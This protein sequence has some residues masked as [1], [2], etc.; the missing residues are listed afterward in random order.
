M[1]LSSTSTADPDLHA[2]LWALQQLAFLRTPGLLICNQPATIQCTPL[3]NP[4]LHC[5]DISV[6]AT[7]QLAK[8]SELDDVRITSGDNFL[9]PS[10]QTIEI[11]HTRTPP[12]PPSETAQTKPPASTEKPADKEVQTRPPA[13][14]NKATV[15]P[16]T[17]AP[18][19]MAT[20]HALEL[21]AQLGLPVPPEAKQL[22]GQ[23]LGLFF[24]GYSFPIT[25]TILPPSGNKISMGQESQ[26]RSARGFAED[27]IQ[28]MKG[29]VQIAY[30]I[31][32]NPAERTSI[33]LFLTPWPS[34]RQDFSALSLSFGRAVGTLLDF[35][36]RRAIAG[37]EPFDVHLVASADVGSIFQRGD[38]SFG[39]W[40]G[41]VFTRNTRPQIPLLRVE[42]GADMS[43]QISVLR[44]SLHSTL[45]GLYDPDLA[46]S[47]PISISYAQAY[48][49]TVMRFSLDPNNFLVP[50]VSSYLQ[51]TLQN[52]SPK[53]LQFGF[54]FSGP[55]SS[56]ISLN[57]GWMGIDKLAPFGRFNI[58]IPLTIFNASGRGISGY[59]SNDAVFGP[60]SRSIYAGY[61]LDYPLPL[62]GRGLENL[63]ASAEQKDYE[64]VLQILQNYTTV[65]DVYR[66][67][68]EARVRPTNMSVIGLNSAAASELA[69]KLQTQ[70]YQSYASD[71]K[72][73]YDVL[74]Q[75]KDQELSRT[76]DFPSI[77][78]PEKRFHLLEDQIKQLAQESSRANPVLVTPL[79]DVRTK[80]GSNTLA[81]V[82]NQFYPALL[83]AKNAADLFG[84]NQDFAQKGGNYLGGLV[85]AI[86]SRLQ[87]FSDQTKNLS[88]ANLEGYVPPHQRLLII[89]N[90]GSAKIGDD[91]LNSLASLANSLNL[92]I[93]FIFVGKPDAE[94][95]SSLQ[96]L[97][98]AT[99]GVVLDKTGLQESDFLNPDDKAMDALMS[100]YL[101]A[102]RRDPLLGT[103]MTL[104]NLWNFSPNTKVDQVMD[105][106][107]ESLQDSG[108]IWGVMDCSHF[109]QSVLAPLASMNALA[110]S[111]YRGEYL[112][113][114]SLYDYLSSKSLPTN[115]IYGSNRISGLHSF[116]E[117]QVGKALIY[118]TPE[119]RRKTIV[120]SSITRISP[121]ELT[122]TATEAGAGTPASEGGKKSKKGRKETRQ[123]SPATY[124]IE[125]ALDKAGEP[126]LVLNTARGKM[127]VL[128]EYLFAGDG[129]RFNYIHNG[130]NSQIFVTA[131]K[132]KPGHVGIFTRRTALF[133]AFSLDDLALVDKLAGYI[134]VMF[135]IPPDVRALP[136][137]WSSDRSVFRIEFEGWNETDAQ[138]GRYCKAVL[139]INFTT[140]HAELR[141]YQ[142]AGKKFSDT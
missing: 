124:Y 64:I 140:G 132:G 5:V 69:G 11:L 61:R 62:S 50:G 1:R 6:S 60:S 75:E 98:A 25:N 27:L 52:M 57:G 43:Y 97:A 68:I 134:P 96:S 135:N 38:V 47:N 28:R 31:N 125:H 117:V 128:G 103:K 23:G 118:I 90:G 65:L 121:Y 127:Q 37:L 20:A 85:A 129:G 51:T 137:A 99:G 136:P 30:Q 70:K 88:G 24:G 92:R 104:A 80:I 115:T 63:A 81:Y 2:S 123:K 26:F 45:R 44:L 82:D 130:P 48:L 66:Q 94:A 4:A 9:H 131:I 114:G 119:R 54:T 34:A 138:F 102:V 8:P 56:S 100:D 42:L 142:F 58:Q 78:P 126:Y 122:I 12:V 18:S 141:K 87:T 106:R 53:D 14:E 71:L 110:L 22:S 35:Q 86:H 10:G 109:V 17:L 16:P 113:S 36:T 107:A 133:K 72:A 91:E 7:I 120:V 83:M 41:N 39:Q 15:K 59:V 108:Y 73:K 21:A 77:A 93:D 74:C 105:E 67:S 139:E 116:D 40:Q 95:K 79:I 46:S 111:D 13:E 33:S 101:K 3:P 19:V 76:V 84:P 32:D 55:L 29:T 112:E 49:N 89:G